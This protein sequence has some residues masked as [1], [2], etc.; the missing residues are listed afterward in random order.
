MLKK[1]LHQLRVQGRR[2]RHRIYLAL[3][4]ITLLLT[5]VLSGVQGAIAQSPPLVTPLSTQGSQ[6]IDAQGQPVLLRGVNWFGIETETHAPHGLWARGYREMLQQIHGLGYNVIRLPYSVQMLRSQTVSGIDFNQGSNRELQG[7]TPLEVMDLVIQAAER[8][9][10]LI[11]LD[12]HRLNDQ[13]IPELWYGDGFSEQDWI[14]AWEQL[15]RRYRN[16]KNVIGADLKNEPHGAA[17]W[18]TGDRATD[19]RLAAERA[20]NAILTINP[21]W[22]IVVEG[23]E[24]NVPGQTLTHWW[25][26][27]LEGVRNFPV[28]LSHPEQLVYSPHE[29]GAGVYNQPWFNTPEFPNNLEARWHT[30]FQYIAEENIAPIL[31]GEF[32]GRQVDAQSKEGIWQR[33]LVDYIDKHQLHFTYWSWNPNSGDTGGILRDDWQT[34]DAPKQALLQPLL[35]Q[36]LTAT[37]PSPEPAPAPIP[38]PTPTPPPTPTPTPNPQPPT[39]AGA[40]A[41]KAVIQSDWDDGFCVNFEVTNGGANPLDSWRLHFQMNQATINNS[42]NGDI[43]RQGTQYTITPPGW[44]QVLQPGQT[45]NSIG[46]CA[47][48]TGADYQPRAIAVH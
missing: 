20:G 4:L 34:V 37:N 18:G 41:A 24:K 5:Q 28:R 48:K 13:R 1:F 2:Y 40:I 16:Q 3:A 33:R 43:Q 26:G 47:R 39:S 46:F 12:S 10:L 35:G 15:A 32:G 8:E 22:L 9:G 30:G 25:G 17:S 29:Y 14:G 42:W 31:I 27:N 6:I 11:L 45:N 7:K 23:V 19:W 44:A 21:H 36:S 38:T